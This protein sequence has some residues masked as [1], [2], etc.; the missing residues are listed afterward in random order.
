VLKFAWIR[1]HSAA[2]E[3][4]PEERTLEIFGVLKRKK[5]PFPRPPPIRGVHPQQA[6]RRSAYR[7][8]TENKDSVALEV[9]IPLILPRMKRCMSSISYEYCRPQSDP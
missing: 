5:L 6:D 9:L 4:K 2:P 3:G 7:I 1:R 8:A